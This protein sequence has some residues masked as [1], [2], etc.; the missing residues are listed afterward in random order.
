MSEVLSAFYTGLLDMARTLGSIAPRLLLAMIVLVLCIGAAGMARQ[1][2]TRWLGR[3]QGVGAT[4]RTIGQLVFSALALSGALA[5]LSIAGIDVPALLAGLGLTSLAIGF[6]LRDLIENTAAGLMILINQD[7]KIG[8]VVSVEGKLGEITHLSVRVTKIRTVGGTEVN[9]PNRMMY[10]SVVEN[11]S[12]YP[13][14]RAVVELPFPAG[15][16]ARDAIARSV[17]AAAGVAGVL[18]APAPFAEVGTS[19]SG[20]LRLSVYYFTD[21][22]KPPVRQTDVLLA[23]CGAMEQATAFARG[24]DFNPGEAQWRTS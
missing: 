22:R 14:T 5:A 21:S 1:A 19:A 13:V 16:G 18:A 24:D 9:V 2:L 23:V 10:T 11:R 3:I 4:A 6:A 12:A 7:F 17:D 20:D 8:D 15:P